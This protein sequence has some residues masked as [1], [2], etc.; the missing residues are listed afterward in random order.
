MTSQE[1]NKTY[2]APAITPVVKWPL[3]YNALRSEVPGEEHSVIDAFESHMLMFQSSTPIPGWI[4]QKDKKGLSVYFD[5]RWMEAARSWLHYN[6]ELK[7]KH[8]IVEQAVIQ[9]FSGMGICPAAIH[10]EPR[11]VFDLTNYYSYLD[12]MVEGFDSKVFCSGYKSELCLGMIV[13]HGDKARQYFDEWE[14]AGI[15]EGRGALLYL[16]AYTS[17]YSEWRKIPKVQWVIDNY[18]LFL[19][20][21]VMAEKEMGIYDRCKREDDLPPLEEQ[22]WQQQ[23]DLPRYVV[24]AANRYGDILIVGA[25]H[26]SPAM[27][28]Q[29][30]AIRAAGG[31]DLCA[32]GTEEQ[33][34]IDQW[35]VFMSRKEAFLVAQ[36]ARQLNTRRRKSGNEFTRELFSEDIH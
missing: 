11:L 4:G 12:I 17:F 16:M 32:K 2:S 26:F 9:P 7:F 30:D 10:L 21:I 24:A 29:L 28:S 1:E 15:P 33:G 35:D 23:N 18:R 34:F 6:T 13:A 3:L 19:P 5:P 20:Y 14:E 22:T 31:E 36:Y 25:R 27:R 8:Y